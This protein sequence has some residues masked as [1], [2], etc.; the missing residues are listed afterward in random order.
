MNATLGMF[1]IHDSKAE[2]YLQPFFSANIE[3][4]KREFGAAINGDGNFHQFTED[5]SLFYLGEFEQNEGKL[6]IELAPKHICNAMTLKKPRLLEVPFGRG[7]VLTEETTP[8]AATYGDGL[9]VKR[10]EQ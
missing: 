9:T 4:A 2:A 10:N 7:S 1:T 5:Y 6:N 3:T 8:T